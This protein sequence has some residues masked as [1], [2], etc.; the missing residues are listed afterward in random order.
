M[1]THISHIECS[2]SF[3]AW[4]RRAEDLPVGVEDV[5]GGVLVA[6]D[7]AEAAGPDDTV[8][9]L[10]RKPLIGRLQ[11]VGRLGDGAGR[12]RLAVAP[13]KYSGWSLPHPA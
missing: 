4:Q 10:V 9:T 1:G 7:A 12:I 11:H 2:D 13:S 3:T 6:L 8:W 5:S